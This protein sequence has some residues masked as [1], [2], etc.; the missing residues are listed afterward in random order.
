MKMTSMFKTP[1]HRSFKLKTRYYNPEKEA[2][3]ER[4]NRARQE[5]APEL[6]EAAATRHRLKLQFQK[7]RSSKSVYS[8]KSS[9]LRI[10]IITVI[11]TALS[12]WI[13]K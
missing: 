4:V 5:E 12:Y 7:K 2:F 11:L 1:S 8:S 13:L 3:E 10:A 9:N 6:S